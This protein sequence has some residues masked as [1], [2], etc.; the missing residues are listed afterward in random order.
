MQKIWIPVYNKK[1]SEKDK[2]CLLR[3]LNKAKPH[4]VLLTFPR[5]LCNKEK[6]NE[7]YNIFMENKQFLNENG[8]EVGAWVFP[9]I[10]YGS[11][12][13]GDNNAK[14]E[15]THIHRL[16]E[17]VDIPGAYCPWDDNFVNEFLNTITHVAKTGVKTIMFEDDFTFGGGKC[18]HD[19][20]CACDAH[21]DEY[22]RR[23]GEKLARKELAEKIFSGGKNK[24]RDLFIQIQRETLIEFCQKIEKI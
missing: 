7:E 19:I 14:Y 22:C 5:I 1:Y 3:E 18:L 9:S 21:M 17:D 2:Q 16:C 11:D 15:Y 20:G 23:I 6:L 13:W 24:Y 10:G 8:I 12:F 4:I